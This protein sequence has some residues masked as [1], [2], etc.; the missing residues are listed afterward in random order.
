TLFPGP[1][2]APG[3]GSAPAA[4]APGTWNA[5][6]RFGTSLQPLPAAF[7][8]GR[9]LLPLLLA[10]GAVLLV[11]LPALLLRGALVARFGGRH[12]AA[13]DVTPLRIVPRG[14]AGSLTTR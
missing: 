14:D 10:L 11:T 6:T 2:G 5:P 9:G 3:S 4:P 12:R 13:E 1:D 7:T 8:D